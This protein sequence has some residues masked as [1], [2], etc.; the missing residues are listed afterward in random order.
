MLKRFGVNTGESSSFELV[1]FGIQML[2]GGI[3]C[4]AMIAALVFGGIES[5]VEF[6][7]I[8]NGDWNVK[9]YLIVV[10]LAFWYMIIGAICLTLINLFKYIRSKSK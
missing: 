1:W 10:G 4:L 9:W 6:R 8:A 5:V 3:F 2:L 7:K